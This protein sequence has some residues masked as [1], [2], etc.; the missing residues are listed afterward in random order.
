MVQGNSK[1][2][3]NI[4]NL[5][6]LWSCYLS[7]F[8]KTLSQIVLVKVNYSQTQDKHW[9][10][11]PIAP[12]HCRPHISTETYCLIHN[13]SSSS[14]FINANSRTKQLPPTGYLDNVQVS[15]WVSLHP[16][17]KWVL[18]D[19]LLSLWFIYFEYRICFCYMLSFEVTAQPTMML[20]M[21]TLEVIW[22]ML[23]VNLTVQN[24]RFADIDL[25]LIF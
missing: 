11:K 16:L 12:M 15:T 5:A 24:A 6:V 4:S 20:W 17:D 22:G 13:W 18:C 3:V 8:T 23:Q 10:S 1:K 25:H 21:N 2:N 14:S 9:R 19:D 7:L